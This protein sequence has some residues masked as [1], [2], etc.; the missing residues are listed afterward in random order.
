MK[1]EIPQAIVFM[2]LYSD[3]KGMACGIQAQ[4]IALLEEQASMERKDAQ[5]LLVKWMTEKKYLQDLVSFYSCCPLHL[6]LM[7]L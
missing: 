1:R 7:Q 3:A 6:Y 5:A 2:C 4:M